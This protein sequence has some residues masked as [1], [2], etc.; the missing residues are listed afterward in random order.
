MKTRFDFYYLKSFIPITL[1]TLTVTNLQAAPDQHINEIDQ[2]REAIVISI[3]Q[4]NVDAGITELRKLL[5]KAPNNQKLIADYLLLALQNKRYL[6]EDQK[7]LQHIQPAYFPAYAQLPLIKAY[8]DK[9]QFPIALNVLNLFQNKNNSSDLEIL[10]AV[11]LAENQQ[12]AEAIAQLKKID[13]EQLNHDQLNQLSYAYRISDQPIQALA[14]IRKSNIE[15]ANT[16]SEQEYLNVLMVLGAYQQVLTL[17]Q[18]NPALD[19]T[20]AVKRQALLGQFS[21]SIK[22]AIKSQKHLAYQG[23]ADVQSYA[24]LDEVLKHP[25]V[26][27]SELKQDPNLYRRFRYEYIYGLSYRSRHRDV[28]AVND[29]LDLPLTDMPAYV[30]HSIA[31][32]YLATKQAA[33]AEKVYKSLLTEKNYADMNVYTSL[34]Y[35]LI[36]QEKYKQA[37][38]LIKDIDSKMPT[39]QYSLA[40]GVDKRVHP[41]R[42]DYENLKALSLAYSNHLNDA[43]NLLTRNIERAPNNEEV[44]NNLVRIQRWREKPQQAEQTLNRL[45]GIEPRSKSTSINQM[46]NQQAL[47]DISA[48]RNQ[49]MHLSQRYPT[50]TSVIKSHKELADRERFSISHDSRFSESKADQNQVLETLKGTKD[51]ESTTRLNS[52]WM[53]DN[54]RVFT[55]YKHRMG[56]YREGKIRDERLG[57]GGEWDSKQKSMSVMLSQD[58]DGDDLG[59]DANWN[60]RLDDHWRYN[61]GFSTQAD[62][63]LQALKLNEDAQSYTAGL[64]WQAN[65]SK[66]ASLQYQATD[67][68]DGNLRQEL[69]ARY[70]QNI[71]MQP[72]HK[73]QLGLSSYLGRNRLD[74]TAYFSPKESISGAIDFNHDWLTWRKYEQSFTQ[75]F[76]LTT[77]FY[78]QTDFDAEPVVDI[79]Y[80]HQWQLTRTWGLQYG[81]G[82]GMHPYDGEKEKKWYGQLG[83]EGK[84]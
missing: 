8:R 1:C 20:H 54:Y 58:L 13:I 41:E 40:K 72:H 38:A 66:Q 11:L 21:E 4:G 50:D 46:Q 33:K 78:K 22:N 59:F 67:I 64:S 51:F 81:V 23:E 31:D 42:N 27:D 45:N 70:Q 7:W 65:E 61:L 82:W 36:E 26:L 12:K 35:A 53:H 80:G 32:A 3:K 43:E 68:S 84:F 77:G 2:Q 83:F 10:K 57:L 48:W 18:K 74:Q 15:T 69:S 60:H 24:Q 17:I 39:F 75:Q 47:G 37:N 14:V 6:E 28:L 52:P 55:Q 34:Y 19:S 16:A 44:I 25:R 56:D 49:T 79:R 5:E 29:N 62:I 9:K 73:T 71:F 30:R 76:S 63:P